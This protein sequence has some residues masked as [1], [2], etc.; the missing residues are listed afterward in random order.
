MAAKLDLAHYG[1]NRLSVLRKIF[2][3]KWGNEIEG[4]KK[5]L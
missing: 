5:Y 4:R 1:K 3:T 2:G